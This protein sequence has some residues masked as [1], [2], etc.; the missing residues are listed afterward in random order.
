MGWVLQ[1]RLMV[2][3]LPSGSIVNPY[4]RL[5]CRYSPGT[6]TDTGVQARDCA[7]FKHIQPAESRQDYYWYFRD[8]RTIGVLRIRE[9][10]PG[11]TSCRR[12]RDGCGYGQ[13]PRIVGRTK[14]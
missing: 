7:R 2:K 4:G 8:L 11:Q 6:N 3:L 12:R 10:G 13:T 1:G 9:Q 5:G 14:G